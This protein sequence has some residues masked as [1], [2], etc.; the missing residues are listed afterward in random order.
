MATELHDGTVVAALS[1]WRLSIFGTRMYMLY[2]PGRHR[3]RAITCFI[4]F[5][6]ERAAARTTS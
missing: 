4:D 5:V 3:T 2:M 6:L 1:D